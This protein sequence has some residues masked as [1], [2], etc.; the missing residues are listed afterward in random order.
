MRGANRSAAKLC[1]VVT[2]AKIFVIQ[3]NSRSSSVVSEKCLQIMKTAV[4]ARRNVPLSVSIK[5]R[6]TIKSALTNANPV[7]SHV[8]GS[9]S[10]RE[11]AHFRVG[12]RA[13]G[14]PVIVAVVNDSLVDV[15]VHLCVE[16]SALHV[17]SVMCMLALWS[18]TWSV[19][20]RIQCITHSQSTVGGRYDSVP[21]IW[22]ADRR[23]PH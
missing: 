1:S 11:S 17:S 7:L 22:R 3:V 12:F 2:C 4:R 6:A 15:N 16:K 21:H 18:R 14:Y 9:A 23:R 10:T 20:Y 8:R 19:L 13:N 5:K